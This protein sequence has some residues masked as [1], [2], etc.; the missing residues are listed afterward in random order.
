VSERWHHTL[1]TLVCVCVCVLVR[2]R[3]S[4]CLPGT[5]DINEICLPVCT[6]DTSF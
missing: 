6:L 1:A 2:V 3:L 5:G 4:V